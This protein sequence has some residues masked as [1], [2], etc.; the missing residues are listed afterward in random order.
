MYF[1]AKMKSFMEKIKYKK[2][3]KP[4]PYYN[5]TKISTIIWKLIN[6]HVYILHSFSGDSAAHSLGKLILSW[7][8]IVNG[9]THT[10][11]YQFLTEELPS[12]KHEG[13]VIQW[14]WTI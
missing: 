7:F 11:P 10:L 5:Y 4:I 8:H 12:V 14:P 1:K 3:A 2:P 9:Y 13:D 6:E